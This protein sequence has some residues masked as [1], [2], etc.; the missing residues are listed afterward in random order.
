[1][2][3]DHKKFTDAYRS[4]FNEKGI[5]EV[6]V[7]LASVEYVDSAALGMLLWMKEKGD[8]CGVKTSISYPYGHVKQILEI[9][10]FKKWMVVK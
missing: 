4:A 8:E 1:V 10:N 3:D 5:N 9:A 7:C 6:E 2:F